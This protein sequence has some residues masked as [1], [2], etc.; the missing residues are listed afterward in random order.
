LR[1]GSRSGRRQSCRPHCKISRT[2]FTDLHIDSLEAFVMSIFLCRKET[3]ILIRLHHTWMA[4]STPAW[5]G[6]PPQ[7]LQHN[8]SLKISNQK[9]RKVIYQ[10]L[11]HIHTPE[12][13]KSSHTTPTSKTKSPKALQPY[14]TNT[15]K[16]NPHHHHPTPAP[17]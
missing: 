11:L 5:W 10:T 13:I 4:P 14:K 1:R 15:P 7:H 8:I 16:P 9:N 6:F 2:V 17:T 3:I 12:A